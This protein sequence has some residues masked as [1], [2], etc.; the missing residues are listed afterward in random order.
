MP[1]PPRKRGP[2][3]R[4]N[5]S[6]VKRLA[7]GSDNEHAV[8]V[9]K[10]KQIGKG[11]NKEDD[12]YMTGAITQA[13]PARASRPVLER[14]SSAKTRRRDETPV[15]KQKNAGYESATSVMGG[16][17]HGARGRFSVG[18]KRGDTSSLIQKIGMG[19]P[20]FES[21][22]LSAF[23]PRPRQP[24]IL[25][26]MADDGSSDLG[27][28]EDFLGGFEPE[29]ESTPMNLGRRKTLTRDQLVAGDISADIDDDADEE[30]MPESPTRRDPGLN[31]VS[32]SPGNPRKRKLIAVVIPST[33]SPGRHESQIPKELPLEDDVDVVE[34][35]E[36]TA[37]EDDDD[38]LPPMRL[39]E[40][41]QSL[42]AW[43]Q[44]RAPPMSSSP[45]PSPRKSPVLHKSSAKGPKKKVKEKREPRLLVSTATLQASVM[46]QRRRRKRRLN[47]K[48]EFD[49]FDENDDSSDRSPSPEIGPDEDELSYLPARVGR[50][51]SGKKLKENKAASNR[52]LTQ[53]QRPVH[54]QK[55]NATSKDGSD[56]RLSRPSTGKARVTYSRRREAD[57]ESDIIEVSAVDEGNAAAKVT[58]GGCVVSEE[59]LQ[60]AKKFAEVDQWT[61]DFE[62]VEAE[63]SSPY[64]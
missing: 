13:S 52:L 50:K 27:D 14:Q 30:Q 62:D 9:S 24:S 16:R 40:P 33:Q 25:Q 49:V 10:N 2:A 58:D 5:A 44:T 3:P 29:D 39:P 1:R 31:T 26:L 34:E 7:Q 18:P 36:H 41:E 63:K 45:L 23:R 22:R 46:P 38:L 61:I 15:T 60:Q 11:K 55:L 54:K 32:L 57:G 43:S 37:S 20:A 6:A 56:T 51:A 48:G 19:T 35:T 12:T 64:R 47:G 8:D 28:D 4:Q 53:G 21:S 59:L 17:G 42:E